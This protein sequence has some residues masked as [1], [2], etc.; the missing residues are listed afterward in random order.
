MKSNTKPWTN[1][2][3]QAVYEYLNTNLS[4]DEVARKY[5][6]TRDKLLY[7][8]RKYKKERERRGGQT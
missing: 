2:L 4:G 1:E 6:I 3:R 5:G 8:V 7:W